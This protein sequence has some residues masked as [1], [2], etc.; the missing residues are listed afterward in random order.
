MRVF[1]RGEGRGATQDESQRL[2]AVQAAQKQRDDAYE[3]RL[4]ADR[5][6]GRRGGRRDSSDSEESEE[7]GSEE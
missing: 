1:P 5:T 2:A 6:G 4:R 3:D 7:S